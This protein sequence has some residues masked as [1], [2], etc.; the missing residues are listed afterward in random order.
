MKYLISF[1]S[2]Q[3]TQYLYKEAPDHPLEALTTEQLEKKSIRNSLKGNEVKIQA[4]NGPVP[5]FSYPGYDKRHDSTDINHTLEQDTPAK[6]L[7]VTTPRKDEGTWAFIQYDS[8]TSGKPKKNWIKLD[9]IRKTQIE[10]SPEEDNA[11]IGLL[12]DEI[13]QLKAELDGKTEGMNISAELE[14]KDETIAE[15]EAVAEKLKLQLANAQKT[16]PLPVME[17][18]STPDQSDKQNQIKQL[19]ADQ[20]AAQNEI[21]ELKTTINELKQ[22]L[23]SPLKNGDLTK[24]QEAEL[25][26]NL[27]KSQGDLTDVTAKYKAIQD[28]LTALETS[29]KSIRETSNEQNLKITALKEQAGKDAIAL[30][31]LKSDH[32]A[33]VARLNTEITKL[34]EAQTE[35]M[36]DVAAKRIKDLEKQLKDLQQQTIDKAGTDAATIKGLKA[37][38]KIN[39]E[40]I[41]KLTADATN[42]ETQASEN[43]KTME[44][45]KNEIT[46]LKGVE[47]ENVRLKTRLEKAEGQLQAMVEEAPEGTNLQNLT[48]RFSG[49]VAKA[50][51]WTRVAGL[52]EGTRPEEIIPKIQALQSKSEE[53]DATIKKLTQANKTQAEALKIQAGM[54]KIDAREA[55]TSTTRNVELQKLKDFATTVIASAPLITDNGKERD[56][57]TDEFLDFMEKQRQS[58]DEI[59]AEQEQLDA[60]STIISNANASGS[61]SK[62]SDA[63]LDITEILLNEEPVEPEDQIIDDTDKPTEESE[64]TNIEELKAQNNFLREKT[65]RII[66]EA[67][68]I[69]EP[70]LPVNRRQEDAHWVL[71][72]IRPLSEDQPLTQ[73]LLLSENKKL[74][75]AFKLAEDRI[76]KA[77]KLGDKLHKLKL[78]YDSKNYTELIATDSIT[79]NTEAVEN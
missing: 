24:K 53:D 28:R 12:R 4:P 46:R 77:A 63:L 17:P 65:K 51:S 34:T 69:M 9:H 1:S 5:T 55:E 13:K 66:A 60:I 19:T 18:V 14:E 30:E 57:T 23:E 62:A 74:I 35:T 40:A 45:Q 52:F 39:T 6:I 79:G 50:K 42:A 76:P 44:E 20:T 78:I 33:E 10:T 7:M 36:T 29:N 31:K 56:M 3:A 16:A 26:T 38:A 64:K 41:T 73:Q 61:E 67:N 59:T 22:K 43:L 2:K 58:P 27:K 72:S 37:Q 11:E 8:P 21:T 25:Q 71:H 70:I 15:L 47:A 32:Q 48:K 75:G 49:F 54:K 68:K